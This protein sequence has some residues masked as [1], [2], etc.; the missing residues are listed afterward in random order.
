MIIFLALISLVFS[1]DF[2][3]QPR[4]YLCQLFLTDNQKFFVEFLQ[5][6][7]ESNL[8]EKEITRKALFV[9]VLILESCAQN[10]SKL[11]N[12]QIAEMIQSLSVGK[13][14]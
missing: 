13:K 6:N 9:N 1:A 8:L 10:L 14:T 5:K 3:F 11:S 2:S 12:T 7:F 4:L